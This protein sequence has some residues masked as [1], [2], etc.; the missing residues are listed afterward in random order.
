MSPFIGEMEA[1]AATNKYQLL[2]TTIN[3]VVEKERV[4]DGGEGG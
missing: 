4:V 3:I 1:F 2:T